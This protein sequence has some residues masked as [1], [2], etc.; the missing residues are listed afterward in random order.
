[1]VEDGHTGRIAN[2]DISPVI[3]A[4]MQ[5]KHARLPP[6][7]SWE[8]GDATRLTAHADCSFDAVIDKGTLDALAC[9]GDSTGNTKAM[10]RETLRVLRPGGVF[11]MITYGDPSSRLFVLEPL[12]WD[13]SLHLAGACRSFAF[14]CSELTRAPLQPRS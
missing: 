4:Y 9:G 12:A 6:T 5:E 3:T 1:M 11:I 14:G 10:A 7:V 2:V 13:I 8:V